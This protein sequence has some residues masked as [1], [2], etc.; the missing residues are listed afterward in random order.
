MPARHRALAI[1]LL[2]LFACT[3]GATDDPGLAAWMRVEGAQFVR[4]PMPSGQAEG[5]NVDAILLPTNTV[6]P[7]LDGKSLTGSLDAN[8]V[9]AAL[10][11]DTD[12]GYW[13]VPAGPPDVATPTLPSYHA[14][15]AFS[16][17]L[18]A[19]SYTLVVRAVDANGRFGAPSTQPLTATPTSPALTPPLGALVVTL[20]WDTESDLD[21]HVV[22]PLGD[23]IFHG[24][25]SSRPPLSPGTPPLDD[26]GT[27]GVLDFDSNAQCVID[28]RRQ[29][30]AVWTAVPPSGHYVVRVDTS[31]LCAESIAHWTVQ[32]KLGGAVVSAA[33]G[34]SVD[35]DTRG[36]HDRGAGVTA[37]TFDVP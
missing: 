36:A 20:S 28:G 16:P 30:N 22:D 5:P 31:S 11:I 8:A 17:R 21:L 3:R 24:N 26:A 32:A 18:V 13:I 35:A 12:E 10:A 27:F 29:E 9:S 4:G 15:L 6:W 7:G 23:E 25:P 2:S 34:V 33:Q 1:A 14:S 19:G 37:L